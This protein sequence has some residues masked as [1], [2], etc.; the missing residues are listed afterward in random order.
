MRSAGGNLR[1][2]CYGLFTKRSVFFKRGVGKS[3]FL[4]PHRRNR[5]AGRRNEP[6]FGHER[7]GDSDGISLVRASVGVVR[8]LSCRFTRNGRADP[9]SETD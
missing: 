4:E 6:T 1:R 2:F 8:R 3:R 9:V 7:S 5:A